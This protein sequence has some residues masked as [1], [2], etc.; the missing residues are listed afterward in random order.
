[1]RVAIIGNSGSGTST[2]AQQVADARSFPVLHLDSVLEP[3][4][5][6]VLESKAAAARDVEAFCAAHEC[7]VVEGCDERLI[8]RALERA[9]IVLFIAPRADE[10]SISSHLDLFAAY[11]GPRH[12]LT[13]PVDRVFLDRLQIEWYAHDIDALGA[14]FEACAIGAK[15]WTHQAHLVVGLWHVHRYGADEALARLRPGIRRL[16]ESHGGVNSATNGY[17][18]TITAAYVQLL[19]QF[20]ESDAG[21]TSMRDRVVQMLGGPLAGKRALG[22]FYSTERLMSVQARAEWVEP[23]LAPLRLE[24]VLEAAGE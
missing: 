22:A 4:K 19:S 17:H 2:L 14:R 21:A 3:G 7:W 16:N 9:P 5:E 6:S 18:E 23:D 24:P 11:D 10:P 12:L 8:E 1:M 13:A 15:E 20:L